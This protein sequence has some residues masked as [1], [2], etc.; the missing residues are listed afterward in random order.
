MAEAVPAEI[1]DLFA[2]ARGAMLYGY[3]FYPLYTLAAEQL[4]R[5]VEAAVSY[6]YELAGGPKKMSRP[7]TGKTTKPTFED[8]I[9]WLFNTGMLVD[10]SEI[11]RQQAVQW[12]KGFCPDTDEAEIQVEEV[13]SEKNMWHGL[14]KLRNYAS[15]PNRQTIRMPIDAIGTLQSVAGNINMLFIGT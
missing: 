4:Y 12:L 3:F 5:V 14:R 1:H 9:D 7:K 8:K 10:T 13:R 6:K 15:H 2:V 11:Q